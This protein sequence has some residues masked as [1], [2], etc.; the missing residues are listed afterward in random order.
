MINKNNKKVRSVLKLGAALTVVA[1][2]TISAT[3]ALLSAQTEKVQNTFT[4]AGGIELDLEEPNWDQDGE[5][6]HFAPGAVIPKDPT[7]SVPDSSSQNEYVISTV[8][9]FVDYNGDGKYTDDEKVTYDEFTDK[10]A[11]IYFGGANSKKAYNSEDWYTADHAKFYYGKSEAAKDLK[12][13]KKG[14][15]SVLFDTVVVKKDIPAYTKDTAAYKKGQPLAFK[16]DI[17][18]YGVQDSVGQD[19][20]LKALDLMI[21]GKDPNE[22]LK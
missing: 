8:D 2:L 10:Y 6:S 18:S 19:T 20:A 14:E 16:I 4:P 9:Y 17:K 7:V 22:A 3:L 13:F 21:A 15:S 1:G 11:D 5:A 12:V